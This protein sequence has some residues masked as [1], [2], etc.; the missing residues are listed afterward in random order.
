[1]SNSLSWRANLANSL[2][3]RNPVVIGVG[4][5]EEQGGVLPPLR[6]GDV[7]V[8]IEV[9]GDRGRSKLPFNGRSRGE[10]Q[11]VHHASCQHAHQRMRAL[12]PKSRV[13]YPRMLSLPPTL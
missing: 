12:R 6:A 11:F 2:G 10:G 4:L 1:M 3:S 5:A 9:P 13:A 8:V 7:A